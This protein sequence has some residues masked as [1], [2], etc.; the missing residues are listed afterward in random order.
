[1]NLHNWFQANLRRHEREYAAAQKEVVDL[2]KQV[3]YEDVK[4]DYFFIFSR[5]F[6]CL[7]ASE[8][9]IASAALLYQVKNDLKR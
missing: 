2:Q 5:S 8:A 9:S 4:A 7:R 1:M 3:T 6:I